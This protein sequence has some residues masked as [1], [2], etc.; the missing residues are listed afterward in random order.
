MG[1][2]YCLTLLDPTEF[3]G[4]QASPVG[5]NVMSFPTPGTTQTQRG[6]NQRLV[7]PA[8]ASLDSSTTGGGAS[9]LHQPGARSLLHL[10]FWWQR[11]VPVNTDKITGPNTSVFPCHQYCDKLWNP[12][13]P[14]M[15]LVH[16]FQVCIRPPHLQENH[17]H[18]SPYIHSRCTMSPGVG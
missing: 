2:Q 14:P 5:L 13:S 8:P 6:L 1:T 9:E 11:S 3:L 4:C 7:A 15:V 10:V 16:K 12:V 17:P 18:I